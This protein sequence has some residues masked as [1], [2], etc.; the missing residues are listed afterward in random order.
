MRQTLSIAHKEL[1]I[2]LVS[3]LAYVAATGFLFLSGFFF[4]T[5]LQQFNT[6]LPQA[7]LIPDLNPSLNEWVVTPYF[8]TVSVLLLFLIPVL[9]MRSFAEERAQGTYEMLLT[10]P[11]SA[12]QLVWGKFLGVSASVG[13]LLLV[14]LVFPL[15]LIVFAD[16]EI[17]PVMV[18]FLGLLLL[19]ISY[20]ALGVAVSVFTSSQT[21]AAVVGIIL[22]TTL[23]VADLP[24][25]RFGGT[26]ADILKY[27]SP[28]RHGGELFSGV[29]NGYNLVYFASLIALAIFVSLRVIDKERWR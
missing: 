20:S 14:S 25:G 26:I 7:A 23:S 5:L 11:L 27:V 1:K 6:F 2:T 22:L 17:L 12:S 3:P 16:P 4:F 21:L 24:A 18:G 8:H 28:T 13:L 15:S 19:A 29:I 10:S 9:T